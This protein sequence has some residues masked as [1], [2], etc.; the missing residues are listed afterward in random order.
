MRRL[1]C[2]ASRSAIK[3]ARE[4][5]QQPLHSSP[6][7]STA[8]QNS[9]VTRTMT[10]LLTGGT[11][12]VVPHLARLLQRTT[13]AT[14][15][16]LT[17]RSPPEP[18]DSDEFAGH[19]VRFDYLDP[20]THSEP[21][22][23]PTARASPITAVYLTP[24]ALADP[25]PAMAAFIDVAV[26]THG[27]RRFVLT[28][29]NAAAKGGF[30]TGGV[31]GHLDALRQTHGV[32]YCVLKCTWFDENFAF[33]EHARGIREEGRVYTCTGEAGVPF[34]AAADIAACA[35]VLLLED[36]GREDGWKWEE[37]YELKGP[38][39]LEHGKVGLLP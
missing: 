2:K 16:L 3:Q 15:I 29:G 24:P 13:P 28:T 7:L 30:H 31:W 18:T 19:F 5:S 4:A 20:S 23:H 39:V 10:I 9:S 11:G 12:F 37:S 36:G 38:E 35:A 22:T 6:P 1:A 33:R 14:P 21:F 26:L 25:T 17:S 8:F 34:L 32:E 27:V